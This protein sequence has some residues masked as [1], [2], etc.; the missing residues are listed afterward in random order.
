MAINTHLYRTTNVGFDQINTCGINK[1]NK[2]GKPFGGDYS[3]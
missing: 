1:I 3:D 2:A